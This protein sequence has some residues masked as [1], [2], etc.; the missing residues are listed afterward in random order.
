[1]TWHVLT[2]CLGFIC[3]WQAAEQQTR[4]QMCPH[5]PGRGT[6]GGSPAQGGLHAWLRGHQLV[7]RLPQ[8]C[9][10]DVRRPV[11]EAEVAVALRCSVARFLVRMGR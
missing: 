2:V 5:L 4:Q 6:S 3:S 7:G 11:V 10:V 9:P 1:M 8:A